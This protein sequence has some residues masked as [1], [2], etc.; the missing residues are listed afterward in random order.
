MTSLRA[1]RF[2]I[3]SPVIALHRDL[4]ARDRH[5]LRRGAHCHHHHHHHHHNPLT[6]PPPPSPPPP[7]SRRSQVTW[8]STACRVQIGRR[9]RGGGSSATTRASRSGMECEGV[10]GGSK[11][12][13]P[14]PQ[15]RDGRQRHAA[16]AM[17]WG[18]GWWGGDEPGGGPIGSS[19][20]RSHTQPAYDR[21]ADARAAQLMHAEPGVRE[22]GPPSGALREAAAAATVMSG[23]PP[24]WRALASCC[25]RRQ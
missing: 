25:R 2:F 6:R 13:T 10:A 12:G 5:S 24:A 3:P 19:D 9:R 17:R 14:S 15:T 18:A 1:C 7:Y 4:S 20:T 16:A 23:Q 8:P 21:A 11:G 22:H